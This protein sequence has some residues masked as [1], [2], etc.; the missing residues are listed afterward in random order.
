MGATSSSGWNDAPGVPTRQCGGH[1]STKSGA[2]E[3]CAP[4]STWWSRVA[5]AWSYE[6]PR[7]CTDTSAATF[8]PPVTASDPPSQKSF[9][10]STMISAGI[11]EPFEHGGECG[12]P[13]GELEPLPRH[14]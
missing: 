12:L 5:T 4:G 7:T 13:A 1:E 14:G 3:K 8:A 2:S 9:C 10:T 6:L 11:S